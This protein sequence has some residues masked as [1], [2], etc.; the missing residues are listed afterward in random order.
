MGDIRLPA[1]SGIHIHGWLATLGLHQVLANRWPDVTLRWE[2]DVPVLT[3]GPGSIA[4]AAEAVLDWTVRVIPEGGVLPDCPP[5]WPPPGRAV[6]QGPGRWAGLVADDGRLHP[7][8]VMHAA[9]TLRGCIT[10][11]GDCLRRHPDLM[12]AALTGLGLDRRYG[13][14]LWLLRHERESGP[15]ASAGRDWLALMAL[16][17][18]PV[19]L[20][21]DGSMSAAGWFRGDPPVLRWWLWQHPMGVRATSV[22][23]MLEHEVR[24]QGRDPVF[25]AHRRPRR[26]VDRFRPPYFSPVQLRQDGATRA[27]SGRSELTHQD[28]RWL[29]NPTDRKRR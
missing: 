16:P 27:E 11:V 14:G 13:A 19:R 17:T 9:Q 3:G 10:K 1:L 6:T 20:G 2:Q 21:V 8:L 28:K 7:I 12:L 18:M 25:A 4:E 15:E 23:S 24:M 22:A 29:T 5:E 26:S